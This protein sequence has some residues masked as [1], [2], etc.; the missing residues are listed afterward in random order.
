VDMRVDY[1][2]IG[3]DCGGHCISLFFGVLDMVKR[4]RESFMDIVDFQRYGRDSALR[5]NFRSRVKMHR[6]R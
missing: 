6:A 2:D 5:S 4:C 3:C 1:W